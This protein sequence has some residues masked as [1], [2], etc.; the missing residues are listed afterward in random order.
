MLLVVFS[1]SFTELCCN[2]NTSVALI[3]PNHLKMKMIFCF[4]VF[5]SSTDGR[6]LR[7]ANVSKGWIE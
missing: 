1:H 2:S 4:L 5:A 7:K 6:S 3:N